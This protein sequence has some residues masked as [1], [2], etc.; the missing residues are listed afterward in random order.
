MD[1]HARYVEQAGWT[2][3]N[4]ARLMQMCRLPQAARLLEVGC[5][6]G[7]VLADTVPQGPA[8]RL[9]GLDIARPPLEMAMRNAPQAHY[10]QGDA[11]RLPFPARTFDAVF[12]HFLLLWLPDPLQA[13]REMRRVT[14]PGGRVLALAEP[15]YGGRLD[16]PP[17][18][19]EAGR[20]QT[21]ALRA[22]GA[23]PETG[24]HLRAL[25]TR[26]GLHEIAGG[27][28]GA[29]WHTADGPEDAAAEWQVFRQDMCHLPHPPDEAQIAV[30]Q[31]ADMC[32]R[33]RGERVLFV[34]VCYAFGK[35]P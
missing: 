23:Q 21:R 9:F 8:A 10:T 24:R 15:D 13:L 5:G 31:A 18:L 32:A 4:R 6:T 28:L 7:A 20:W 17:P 16:A 25:F 29:E 26:A 22:Q 30:W 11:L 14:R 27:I 35:A 34:P 12:S 2:R 3:Q 1:W 33:Q 19:D